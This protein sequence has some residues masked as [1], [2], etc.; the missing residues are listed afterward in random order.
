MQNDKA[1]S[2][3]KSIKE[4]FGIDNTEEGRI[5]DMQE[6]IGYI[7]NSDVKPSDVYGAA[8]KRIVNPKA[9]PPVEP[10]PAPEV[11][12]P[13]PII[14][15]TRKNVEPDEN[16]PAFIKDILFGEKKDKPSVDKTP[17]QEPT[18]S[19]IKP[20]PPMPPRP[21]VESKLHISKPTEE[22]P[23][24]APAYEEKPT[25]SA[26][27]VQSETPKNG[28]IGVE[29]VGSIFSLFG[30]S[31][32][33]KASDAP[34][35]PVE[36]KTQYPTVDD[37]P[38]LGDFSRFEKPQNIVTPSISETVDTS[39][40]MPSESEVEKV[41]KEIDA[42]VE[43]NKA[44]DDVALEKPSS[45]NNDFPIGKK[46]EPVKLSPETPKKTKPEQISIDQAIKERGLSQPYLA[47]P[48]ELLF[49][50]DDLVEIEDYADRIDILERT[51]SQFKV[52]AKVIG[53]TQGP[54][55]SRFELKMPDGVSV[56]NVLKLDHDL[57]MKLCADKIRFE[58]PIPGRDAFG[59]EV[60]N[61]KRAT[62]SLKN[63]VMSEEFN[64]AKSILTFALGKDIANTN[65][66]CDLESMPHMLIA[67][68]TGSGKSVCINSLIVSLLYRCG[69]NDLKLILVDPKQ[70]ELN[71]YSGLP[72][73]LVPEVIDDPEIA[74]NALDWLIVE[75]K[76]RFQM[77]KKNEVRNIAEYNAVA[78][79]KGSGLNKIPRIV[80]VID[81]LADFILVKKKEI[82]DRIGKITRLSRAAGIHLVVATQR[83]S[84]DIVT[85][86]IKSNLPSRIAFAVTSTADSMTILGGGGAEKLL[87][88]GDMLYAPQGKEALRLQCTLVERD[89]VKAVVDY[90]KA[91][92]ECFYDTEIQNSIYA[93]N[94]N[95]EDDE[96]T[97]SP[98]VGKSDQLFVEALRL[99]VMEQQAS[100]SRLQMKFSIG[101][102]TAAKLIE[103]ME[104][105]RYVSSNKGGNKRRDVLLSLEQFNQIYGVT[106]DLEGFNG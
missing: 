43:R 9:T 2:K 97:D 26:E 80:C 90:I 86:T 68:A 61:R 50:R 59:I 69:P 3:P 79:K 49:G 93:Q 41:E 1:D 31:K 46:A 99:C 52:D 13:Q 105:K 98:R 95:E 28:G 17:R 24:Q 82:E 56:N 4:A 87:G 89:E 42:P 6:R 40:I 18:V 88:K 60:P 51:L 73:L 12:K 29:E 22:K 15:D 91:N 70:V 54:T 21:F 36:N 35:K 16:M 85:G 74:I 81:E 48:I 63:L 30:K 20:I 66:V 11:E 106:D 103:E 44:K 67:G 65:N 76:E 38:S 77:F 64:R 55:F 39:V 104:Q 32:K 5:K 19:E 33:P 47:P 14:K 78:S 71:L 101:Y 92:N 8:S 96:S 58:A 10:E 25:P 7:I 37:S 72:H 94:E 34:A 102:P 84:V 27:P 45:Y 62:V 100:I 57:A 23:S 53:V 75:M 83:P